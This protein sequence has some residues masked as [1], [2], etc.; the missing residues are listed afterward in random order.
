MGFFWFIIAVTFFTLWLSE[1]SNTKSKVTKAHDSGYA[2]SYWEFRKHIDKLVAVSKLTNANR[3]DIVGAENVEQSAPDELERTEASG[4]VY[5][6]HTIAIVQTESAGAR[7]QEAATQHV[8]TPQQPPAALTPEEILAAKERRTLQN[9]NAMLYVGS[10]LIV[11]AA[12]LFVTLTMPAAVKLVSI[13]FTTIAFYVTG[14]ILHATSER[15]R[16]AA[17]AFVGTGLA[18]I[19]FVGMALHSLAGISSEVAWLTISIVGLIAYGVAAVRLQSQLVSYLTIAFVLSLALSAVATLSLAIVWYFIALIGVATAFGALQYLRPSLIPSLFMRPV[20]Q[21]S[22]LATPI[23]LLASIFT[24]TYMNS[25][26][27]E[28]LYGLA[29]A[30][31]LLVWLHKRSSLY[32]TIVRGLA[33]ATA[34]IV[35]LDVAGGYRTSSEILLFN[36]VWIGLAA[37]Q[38]V[39][40][41][42]RASHERRAIETTWIGVMISLV[43]VHLP[44]WA[45]LEHGAI[46]ICVGLTVIV[47]M[48]LVAMWRF[49]QVGWGYCALIAS[50]L[51][52]FI[53]GRSAIEPAL[54]FDG[55]ALVFAMLAAISL[56]V[57]ERV[58]SA[59]RSASVVTLMSAVTVT[60]VASML[61][62]GMAHGHNVLLGWTTLVASVIMVLLSYIHR[63]VI[64][65]IIA[66]VLLIVS[67][68]AWV[69]WLQT[70]LD[71][72]WL[73]TV[74]ISSVLIGG[75]AYIHHVYTETDRRNALA[76]V[77]AV[78]FGLLA[79][80]PYSVVHPVS[81]IATVS[82]VAAGFGMLILR[83]QSWRHDTVLCKVSIIAYIVYP[84]LALGT[85]FSAGIGWL[86]L[87]LA[88]LTIVSWVSSVYEK[89]PVMLGIGNLFFVCMLNSLWSW[90][91][92]DESWRFYGIIWLGA[93][94][95]YAAY[96]YYLGKNDS[97]RLR[98]SLA[99][100]LILLGTGAIMHL[101]GSATWGFAAASS[102]LAVAGVLGIHG[103]AYKQI[104]TVE[105]AV[106]VATLALQRMTGLLLP[107]VSSVF[108]AHW[109]AI[110]IAGMAIRLNV[111]LPRMIFALALI[112]GS[113]GLFAL[114]GESGYILL[115]LI[116]HLALLVAGGLLRV[117]W[118]LWWGI[119]S[120]V[121][122]IL[123]FLREYTAFALLF[124]GFVI[125][126]IVIWRLLV[127][128]KKK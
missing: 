51:L 93:A 124:L 121:I 96:W 103:A 120:V 16:P 98:I 4:E 44:T 84:L 27:Y 64:G 26:M 69:G 113:T 97:D 109:W 7:Q 22:V 38:V 86:T 122:A 72:W 58:K 75:A 87:V 31:Y 110:V 80:V 59:G 81:E 104:N 53:L 18:I 48:A 117:Q 19:P 127:V 6:D 83:M 128:G 33:H 71:W 105:I 37:V 95:N 49:R 23:A 88:A 8:Y 39:Y 32:E 43:V 74:L 99:S 123:Y 112:T 116:E 115:F 1:K 60:Y 92:F 108:Y 66:A 10:F 24:F 17:V 114:A 30:H 45:L 91:G 78:V 119:V 46:G 42:V 101:F 107:D 62:C 94:V 41:L 125:I 85:A 29:T 77:G 9:L 15:L 90:L 11:A 14:L 13:I 34:L 100:V 89:L 2:E 73:V 61:V 40:S 106:Y 25:M 50:V 36:I 57:T 63:K 56:V 35:A 20:E 70:P 67:V 126:L 68:N 28:V 76:I 5:D 54:P 65:E 52:P 47:A 111:Y 12:A 118:A 102:L 55:I 79:L 21:T 82:L 3:R